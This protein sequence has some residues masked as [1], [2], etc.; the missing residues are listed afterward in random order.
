MSFDSTATGS[1]AFTGAPR[2]HTIKRKPAPK[3][4]ESPRNHSPLTLDIPLASTSNPLAQVDVQQ[5]RDLALAH[6]EGYRMDGPSF[7]TSAAVASPAVSPT[8]LVATPESHGIA[9]PPP[10]F[11]ARSDSRSPQD[12]EPLSGAWNTRR[13][14]S[15]SQSSGQMSR[16][17][18]RRPS[19]SH[20]LPHRPSVVDLFQPPAPSKSAHVRSDPD[21]V[22]SP[23][24]AEFQSEDLRTL[25]ASFEQAH[26]LSRFESRTS[27]F[28]SATT[29]STSMFDGA[30]AAFKPEDVTTMPQMT[31][32]PT[33]GTMGSSSGTWRPPAFL[34]RILN[35]WGRMAQR[36]EVTIE[37][38][39]KSVHKRALDAEREMAPPVDVSLPYLQ[40]H[41]GVGP[42]VPGELITPVASEREA[43]WQIDEERGVMRM[44]IHPRKLKSTQKH[45]WKDEMEGCFSALNALKGCFAAR[46]H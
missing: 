2:R 8:T 33:Q 16:D 3:Y 23:V 42:V 46:R 6:L 28:V 5:N 11:L 38:E 21:Y 31:H 24:T 15:I 14:S 25:N 43:L 7:R 41:A 18:S 29:G 44:H 27:T 19:R 13:P 17:V 4:L 26:N 32:R 35:E 36:G 37:D 1:S 40:E 9:F 12:R 20:R 10:A 22:A 34:M 30:S 45:D 39:Y